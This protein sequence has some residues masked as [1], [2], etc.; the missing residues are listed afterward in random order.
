MIPRAELGAVLNRGTHVRPCGTNMGHPAGQENSKRKS[1][2][3]KRSRQE[4]RMSYDPV[5]GARGQVRQVTGGIILTR[6]LL[7][8]ILQQLD[9]RIAM[10]ALRELK[11]SLTVRISGC[12][13]CPSGKKDFRGLPSKL[14]ISATAHGGQ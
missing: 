8:P 13:V 1:K 14:F 7:L 6:S 12:R 11:G 2:Q 9:D 10:D 4:F 5:R 3:V